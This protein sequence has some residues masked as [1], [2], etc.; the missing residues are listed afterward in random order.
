M[1]PLEKAAEEELE[2]LDHEYVLIHD[3]GN[4]AVQEWI[5]LHYPAQTGNEV[6]VC[7]E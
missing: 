5:N 1:F 2:K 6:I 4:P 3:S 7:G